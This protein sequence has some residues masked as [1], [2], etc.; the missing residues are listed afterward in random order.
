MMVQH[1]KGAE[2]LLRDLGQTGPAGWREVRPLLGRIVARLPFT[3]SVD[4]MGVS[5]IKGGFHLRN[6]GIQGGG[7]VTVNAKADQLLKGI[8]PRGLLGWRRLGLRL[9]SIAEAMVLNIATDGFN[10]SAIK[11]GLHIAPGVRGTGA[12]ITHN[13]DIASA[14][15]GMPDRGV[16]HWETL[17]P[18]MESLI[19]RLVIRFDLQGLTAQ[20]IPHGIHLQPVAGIPAEPPACEPPVITSFPDQTHYTTDEVAGWTVEVAFTGSLTGL[21]IAWYQ[22]DVLM[23]G[24]TSNSIFVPQNNTPFVSDFRVVVTNECGTDEATMTF[25]VIEP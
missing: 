5:A 25:T 10:V 9:R 14:L 7:S 18:V 3:V 24:E 19:P 16:V 6:T 1:N 22:D 12:Q 8:P 17:R 20:E 2:K 4:S 21:T 13:A 11:G 23:V 15:A